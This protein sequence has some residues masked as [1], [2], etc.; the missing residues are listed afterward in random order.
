MAPNQ[1]A[2]SR[3]NG[4]WEST[5]HYRPMILESRQTPYLVHE[6][7]Y[8]ARRHQGQPEFHLESV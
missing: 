4:R 8:R 6:Q 1:R 3:F 2:A 7:R 5:W